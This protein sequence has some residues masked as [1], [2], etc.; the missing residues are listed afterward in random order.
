MLAL[1]QASKKAEEYVRLRASKLKKELVVVRDP[2]LDTDRA[3]AFRFNTKEWM[4]TQKFGTSL[5]GSGPLV[6][7]K[8]TGEVLVAPSANYRLWLREYDLTGNDLN[9]KQLLAVATQERSAG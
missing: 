4:Q 2:S 3:W 8:F 9:P 5:L 7:N 6:V 1:E